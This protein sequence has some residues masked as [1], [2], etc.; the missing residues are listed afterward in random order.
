VKALYKKYTTAEIRD[1]A[2]IHGR[3]ACSRPRPDPMTSN[4]K[5]DIQSTTDDKENPVV[6]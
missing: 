3:R 5:S 6:V 1:T 4:S 2:I